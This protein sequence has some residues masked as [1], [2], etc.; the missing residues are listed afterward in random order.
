MAT[1]FSNTLVAGNDTLAHF[2]AWAQFIEDT[3]I[4]TG[5]WVVTGDTGQTLPS[6]LPLPSV[7]NTKYGY[8]IYRMNDALQ[9][10]APVFLRVDFGSGASASTVGT[11][12]TAG[13]GSNGSGTITGIV[14]NAL[15]LSAGSQ[16]TTASNSYGSADVNRFTLA[17]F[18][19]TTSVVYNHVIGLERSKDS[20]GN[21]TSDGLIVVCNDPSS[22]GAG[23]LRTSTYCILAGG[24]QPATEV[25]VAF[26]LT[27]QNPTQSFAANNIGV[28][29][30]SCFK[31]IAVQPGMN[32]AIVN[33]SDVTA[34]G[35]FTM[36]IYGSS[37]TYQQVR[38]TVLKT[39]AAAA[40]TN[41]RTCIRYD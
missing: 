14:L 31:A 11:W 33:S 23:I 1:H 38:S 34:E 15:N 8:R 16:Q 37:R 36:T 5:S 27:S 41:A 21:D 12:W 18:V 4:T 6:A 25:G 28:G 13:T 32:F 20:N 22:G 35:T 9:A 19:N 3:L 7:A 30:I 24:T 39:N 2:Q 26:I 40:D 17:M 10:T 29:L